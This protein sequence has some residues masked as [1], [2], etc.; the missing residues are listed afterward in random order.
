[1]VTLPNS[2]WQ[3]HHFGIGFVSDDGG[4]A[5]GHV[6]IDDVLGYR[7]G[8][9]TEQSGVV[10]LAPLPGEHSD[11]WGVSGDGSVVVGL[12]GDLAIRR[13]AFRWTEETGMVGLGDL[14]GGEFY[15]VA[16]G[17]SY[18][19]SIVVGRGRIDPQDG[20]TRRAFIW[21]ADHGMRD[22]QQ[23]LIDEHGL[24]DELDGWSLREALGIS[25][26]GTVIW[27]E[28]YNPAGNR[29]TWVAVI[30]EPSTGVL[31]LTACLGAC[32]LWWRSRCRSSA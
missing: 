1:M 14:P 4:V 28:G 5:V 2:K 21:D 24:A 19:G 27:G 16:R 10:L 6:H 31:V 20:Q 29:E 9:W 11:A 15:S 18:D 26:D 25:N 7:A 30:P 22:F 8:R 13:E 12:V 23:L 32:L 3:G 17:V